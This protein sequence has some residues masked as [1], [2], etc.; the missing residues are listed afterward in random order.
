MSARVVFVYGTRPEAIKIAPVVEELRAAL[1]E[2][3]LICTGQHTSLLEG[4][5]AETVLKDSISLG[6][7]SEGSIF[8]WVHHITQALLT[9]H[10]RD[11]LLL[12]RENHVVV[13][14]DTM[15]AFAGA[16]ASA[17]RG[18]RLHHIE[19]GVRSFASE[20]WPEED[21]RKAISG[22]ADFHYCATAGNAINLQKEG[23]P[24]ERVSI[25]G[26][27]VVTSLLDLGI[28][29]CA[30]SDPPTILVTLHRRE[31]R[32]SAEFPAIVDSLFRAMKER[33]A[34]KFLWPVHPA[35]N[36]IIM[37]AKKPK[38]LDLVAPM[39]YVDF[40]VRLSTALGLLTDSGGAVEEAATLGVPTVVFRR[41]SDRPEAEEAGIAVRIT[42]TRTSPAPT[43]SLL[44]GGDIQ[45][46]PRA[47][48]G[49]RK[50]AYRIASHI[51][52]ALS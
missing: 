17:N 13:Q 24:T 7:P 26:N 6:M 29:P 5:P 45:R 37:R 42:P 35:M 23:I 25:T 34:V 28:T 8:G 36:D 2:P 27:P 9:L 18:C 10:I 3:V 4:T 16:A 49:D 19:A 46:T 51:K 11:A 31:L 30:A 32:E 48:Y 52:K 20:P 14:G 12:E 40:V 43:L 33:P 1:I 21:I 15:S 47:L 22:M 38:N 44:I 41:Y 50:S 39:S